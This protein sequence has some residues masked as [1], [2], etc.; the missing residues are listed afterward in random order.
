MAPAMASLPTIAEHSEL[1]EE[2]QY[3]EKLP[4]GERIKLAQKRRKQQ[5]SSYGKWIKTDTA[6]KLVKQKAGKGVTFS[7][8]SQLM[9]IAARGSY[10]EMRTLLKT[11]NHQF[12]P[13]FF[14][15]LQSNTFPSFSCSQ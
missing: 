4:V 14:T 3:V 10:E 5:L 15:I 1:V 12:F 13:S 6:S 8:L 2:M 9:E 11:G 7:V